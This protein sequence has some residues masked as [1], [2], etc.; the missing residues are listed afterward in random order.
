MSHISILSK[1]I[2]RTGALSF[3]DYLLSSGKR[4]AYYIDLSQLFN[5]PDVF[6]VISESMRE[7]VEDE[8]GVENVD[9]IAGI[10]M[11]G[12][13]HASQLSIRLGKPLVILDRMDGSALYGAIEPDDRILLIDDILNTGKAM[14]RCVGWITRDAG[15]KVDH[16]AV[17]I[18]RMGGGSEK[19]GRRKTQIH[20]LGNVMDVAQTLL[21]FGAIESGEHEMIIGETRD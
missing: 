18:D 19:L 12:A 9:R 14:D 7:V 11:K 10:S 1:A 21:T 2:I 13:I 8:V 3:G 16:A 4:S 15:G 17:I 5:Y 20:S 6:S